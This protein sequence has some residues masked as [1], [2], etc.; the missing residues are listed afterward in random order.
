MRVRIETLEARASRDEQ[1][2]L[3]SAS[4]SREVPAPS[5]E[6][7]IDEGEAGDKTTKSK[8]VHAQDAQ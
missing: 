7:G 6:A 4:G 2:G 5:T 3:S 8:T 1:G